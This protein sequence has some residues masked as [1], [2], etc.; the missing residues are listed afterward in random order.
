MFFY[1][2]NFFNRLSKIVLSLPKETRMPGLSRHNVC[3]GG[4][5]GEGEL[6]STPYPIGSLFVVYINNDNGLVRN[7]L[8][9]A[10]QHIQADVLE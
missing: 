2:V 3:D 10:R 8:F 5:C 9:H 7:Q 4:W 6:K 1:R